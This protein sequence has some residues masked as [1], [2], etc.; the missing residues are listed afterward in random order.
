MKKIMVL[1]GLF[2][3][4]LIFGQE[5]ILERQAERTKEK[6]KQRAENKVE[7]GIDKTLDKTEE[8]IE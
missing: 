3:S 2:Y 1:I 7:Q 6:I 4:T 8:A 5:T